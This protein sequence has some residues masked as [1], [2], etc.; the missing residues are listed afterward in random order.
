MRGRTDA[1]GLP[2]RAIAAGVRGFTHLYNA[3]SP[4]ASREPGMVGAALDW[5]E[6]WCGLIADGTHVHPAALRLA[7]RALPAGKAMLVTVYLISFL[8]AIHL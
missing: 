8:L 4:F 1:Q 7:T 2:R 6:A 5:G 3:M